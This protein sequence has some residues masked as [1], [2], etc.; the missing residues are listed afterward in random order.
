MW[1]EQQTVTHRSMP[2]RSSRDIRRTHTTHFTGNNVHIFN[3]T[4]QSKIRIFRCHSKP[5]FLSIQAWFQRLNRTLFP[6]FPHITFVNGRT[7]MK[8]SADILIV[9]SSVTSPKS[10]HCICFS[11]D[12]TQPLPRC[13]PSVRSDS[14]T[15]AT[16]LTSQATSV[17]E[18]LGI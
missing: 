2:F 9:T 7:K 4:S 3:L 18:C 16:F 11:T 15:V 1:C 6:L 10:V 17:K 14:G 8:R 12:S 13:V 5:R